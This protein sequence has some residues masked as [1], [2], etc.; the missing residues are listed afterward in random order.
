MEVDRNE[1]L[2][3]LGY[4]KQPAGADVMGMVE[5]CIA[6]LHSCVRPRS[7]SRTFGLE[8]SGSEINMGFKVISADLA[9]HLAG[10]S[11]AVLFSATLGAEADFLMRKATA[12]DMSRAVVMQACAAAFIEAYCDE[13]EQAIAARAAQRGLFLRPRYSPGYGDFP[14]ESQRDIL[15]LL[16]SSKLIGI[17]LTDGFML[18]PTKSVTAVMGLSPGKQDCRE[19]GCR[20]CLSA[21]CPFR[22]SE[23]KQ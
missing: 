13:Q 22:R 19:R 12:S 3:Y 10:C 5:S 11:E 14:I 17:G 21:D 15:A 20:S 1:V 18:V 16:D 8:L 7:L 6:E 4:K 23:E 2:R 9:R